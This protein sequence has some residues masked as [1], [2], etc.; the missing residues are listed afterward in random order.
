MVDAASTGMLVPQRG[1]KYASGP[2]LAPQ[3]AQEDP[4]PR[5][6]VSP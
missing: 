1:Q 5:V 4:P 6:I 2:R 3:R